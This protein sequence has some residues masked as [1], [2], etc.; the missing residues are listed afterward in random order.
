MGGGFLSDLETQFCL[1]L[2]LTRCSIGSHFV[3]QGKVIY[4][5]CT[6]GFL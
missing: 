5:Q 3:T 6:S 2:S 1:P 4:R